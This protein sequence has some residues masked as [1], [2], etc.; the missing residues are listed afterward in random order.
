MTEHV[1]PVTASPMK[2]RRSVSGDQVIFAV[3]L[4]VLAFLVIILWFKDPAHRYSGES[5]VGW[6]PVSSTKP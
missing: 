4:S 2:P 5:R 1:H 3:F 6:P